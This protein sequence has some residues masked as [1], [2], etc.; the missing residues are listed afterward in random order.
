MRI[1]V[2]PIELGEVQLPDGHPRRADGVAIMR[3][4]VVRHPDGIIVYDTG[5]GDDHERLNELYHP[6]VVPIVIALNE[7]GVD[8]RDVIAIVNSHLHFDHCGQNR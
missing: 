5:A 1:T 2:T 8:E 3:G 6:T 4:F 7:A